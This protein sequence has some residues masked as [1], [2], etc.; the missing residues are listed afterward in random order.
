MAAGSASDA[1]RRRPGFDGD[2]GA[3]PSG[4]SPIPVRGSS[5]EIRALSF[6]RRATSCE[7]RTS[8]LELRGSRFAIRDSPTTPHR[9]PTLGS[10]RSSHGRSTPGPDGPRVNADS[11]SDR[12]HRGPTLDLDRIRST[13][14]RRKALRS[15]AVGR[16]RAGGAKLGPSTNHRHGLVGADVLDGSSLT[17]RSCTVRRCG[18]KH[19]APS[20]RFRPSSGAPGRSARCLLMKPTTAAKP[21]RAIAV[22]TGPDGSTRRLWTLPRVTEMPSRMARRVLATRARATSR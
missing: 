6:Q 15:R 8:R 17:G 20:E 13:S 10:R 2:L 16:R 3:P 22:V 5:F 19:A 11:R 18:R 1:R 14:Q 12:P 9:R 4:G 7:V 21:P